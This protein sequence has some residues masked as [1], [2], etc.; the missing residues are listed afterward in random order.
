M[1]LTI[2]RATPEQKKPVP[3][4]D[5][6]LGFGEIFSD[7]MFS[8]TYDPDNGWHDAEI[9]PY[10]S[11][12]M[13]P[14]TSVLHY[15]QAIFEGMKAY[16][17]SDGNINLFRPR[18]NFE[19][20]NRSAVRMC[21]PQLDIDFVLEALEEFVKLEKDWIPSSPGTSLYIRPIII[22]DDVFLGVRPAHKYTFYIIACPVGT[23][24]SSG[25]NPVSIYTSDKYVRA[26]RGGTGD[27][28]T[29]GNYAASLFGAREAKEKGYTQVLWLDAVN[30]K[31]V[32][33]VGTMNIFFSF[34]D[35]VVTPAL[36]GSIL[37][38]ITRKSVISLLQEWGITVEERAVS[39]DEVMEGAA[40]GALKESWGTGT[41]VIVT[42]VGKICYREQVELINN[43]EVGTLS[44][45]LHDEIFNIQ[46]GLKPDERNWIVP[47]R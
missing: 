43:N 44:K 18:L 8:M 34:G 37:P 42:P 2:N 25:F 3:N 12:S 16:K 21:M 33:E 22:A 9:G 35:K 32:E 27:I 6:K 29:I 41:A 24:Y 36:S 23:Y 31:Y 13:D 45:R 30:M 4:N 38:G 17:T 5:S 15:G 28:K 39:I 10:H 40:S 7:H 11:F 20:M 14:A 26:C 19:R 46:H 47:V 1:D